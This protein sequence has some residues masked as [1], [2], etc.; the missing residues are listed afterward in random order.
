MFRVAALFFAAALMLLPA[1]FSPGTAEAGERASELPELRVGV[2]LDYPPFFMQD[3]QG[4]ASGFDFDIASALC[5]DLERECVIL[6]MAFE[7]LL[8]SMK[9]GRLDIIV[10]GLAVKDDRRQYMN[11][12]DS[13]YHSRSIY[14]TGRDVSVTAEWMRGKRLGTQSGT[15]QRMLAERLW[16]DVA[17]LYEFQ[18]HRGMIEALKSG[19]VD[20]VIID[21][22]A[23]YDF[24]LSEE[25]SAFAMQELPLEEDSP[26][27]N[28]CI[29][30]RKDAPR[31][32]NDI[33]KFIH[34]IKLSS[35]YSRIARKYFPFNIY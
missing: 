12:S 31:L 11:F 1:C 14:I 2:E 15:A 22:L 5:R 17:G 9:Q 33:N 21:G 20:I 35:E 30:V 10:A 4:N 3:E 18:D 25:G 16:K 23:A 24:L 6:P 34:D 27:N 19:E 32:L 26:T 8:E 7:E 29:G 28:A 13:Y